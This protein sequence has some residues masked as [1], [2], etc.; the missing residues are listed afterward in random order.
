MVYAMG[1]SALLFCILLVMTFFSSCQKKGS[2]D[3]PNQ[4]LEKLMKGNER[5]VNN[6]SE[7]PNQNAERR[8]EILSKQSPFA[9]IVGCSDSRIPPEIIF[10]AGLG[11]LFVVRVAGNVIGPIE[12]ESIDYAALYLNSSIILVLGH[13]NCGAVN[14]VIDNKTSDIKEIATLI[15]PAVQKAK[16]SN[17]DNLP[18]RAIKINAINMKNYLIKSPNIKRLIEE[19]KIEVQAAYYDLKTGRVEIL[20]EQK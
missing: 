2:N 6:K 18:E 12:Q 3:L 17:N 5:F 14:A 1:K 8:S 10:D 16:E 11:N 20:N 15:E 19:K 4:A 13:E 7:N 9:I